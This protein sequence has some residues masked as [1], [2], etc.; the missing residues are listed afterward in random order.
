MVVPDQ[1]QAGGSDRGEQAFSDGDEGAVYGLDAGLH[2]VAGH[3]ARARLDAGAV[4]V[5]EEPNG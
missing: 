4:V 2:V 1:G 3:S 5:V